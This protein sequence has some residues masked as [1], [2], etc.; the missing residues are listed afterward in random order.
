MQQLPI[1]LLLLLAAPTHRI[2]QQYQLLDVLSK[3]WRCGAAAVGAADVLLHRLA[4]LLGLC[5]MVV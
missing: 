3:H 5:E 2:Q 4:W 1:P